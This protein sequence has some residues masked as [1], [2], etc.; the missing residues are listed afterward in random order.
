MI[1]WNWRISCEPRI[2]IQWSLVFDERE[3]VEAKGSWEPNTRANKKRIGQCAQWCGSLDCPSILFAVR[4]TR[5]NREVRTAIGTISLFISLRSGRTSSFS[6]AGLFSYSA[7]GGIGS[8]FVF[9]CFFAWGGGDFGDCREDFLGFCFGSW[10]VVGCSPLGA[11]RWVETDRSYASSLAPPPGDARSTTTT[12][13]RR[14]TSGAWISA[15]RPRP[16]G[17][18]RRVTSLTPPE[19]RFGWCLTEEVSRFNVY[20]RSRGCLADL[21]KIL[22]F[23]DI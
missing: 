20:F 15:V 7:L 3:N 22:V 9:V 1:R 8:G 5:Q 11:K 6:V 2:S 4:H 10:N 14:P 23:N 16:V 21:E 12:C 19:I 17:H 13:Q 18:A